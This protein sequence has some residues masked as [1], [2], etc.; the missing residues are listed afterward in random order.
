MFGDSEVQ[1]FYCILLLSLNILNLLHYSDCSVEML[2]PLI[3][4]E[5]LFY[6]V[7][8]RFKP[9]LLNTTLCFLL[10]LN[11]LIWYE[12]MLMPVA[13]GSYLW[14]RLVSVSLSCTSY[15]YIFELLVRMFCAGCVCGLT[16]SLIKYSNRLQQRSVKGGAERKDLSWIS[17]LV[18]I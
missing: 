1:D 14:L 13:D 3:K 2:V 11:N 17:F 6:A 9:A 4:K 16:C 15:I 12:M 18:S 8:K 7:S 5:T 10:H